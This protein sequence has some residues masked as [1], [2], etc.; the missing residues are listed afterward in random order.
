MWRSTTKAFT[1]PSSPCRRRRARSLEMRDLDLRAAASRRSTSAKW[2]CSSASRKCRYADVALALNVPIGIGHVA[3]FARTRTASA[4]LMAEQPARC[5][6]TGGAMSDQHTPIT[7]EEAACL[8]GRHAVRRTARRR[9]ARARAESRTGRAHQ[10]LF[11]A[12]QPVPRSLRPRVERTRAEAL[13]AGRAAAFA[14]L[15]RIAANWPQFAGMAAALV[16]GVGIGV[17]THMG[18]DAMQSVAG[19]SVVRRAGSSN[20]HEQARTEP[21]CSPA[22]LRLRTSCICRRSTA[23]PT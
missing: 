23:L 14:P 20:T 3:A 12:E 22:R 2:C 9:R 21:R 5:E 18:Q 6:I 10:R 4:A 8:R 15:A 16:M 17:G 13:A 19:F 1:K 11:F 7:E